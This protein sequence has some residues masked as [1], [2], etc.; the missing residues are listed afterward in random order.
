MPIDLWYAYGQMLRSR[1]FEEAV[2]A[3][4]YQG[5]ISGEMH[6]GLGE[7][8]II[9]GTVC[10]LQAGDALALDHRGTPPL[11]LPWLP[12]I[13]GRAKSPWPILEKEPSTRAW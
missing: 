3:L 4:W 13:C 8:A 6:L 2:A 7:E 12:N 10:H 11:G 9:A 5:C 1:Y